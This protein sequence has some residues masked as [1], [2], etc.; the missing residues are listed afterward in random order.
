MTRTRW[1][2]FADRHLPSIVIYLMVATLVAVLLYPHMVITVPSGFIGVLWKRFCNGTV[3][4][5]RLLKNEG[6]N[7]VAPW[8]QVFLYDLRLQSFTESYNAI[9]SDGVNLTAS[10]VVR[11]R[12]QR[13]AVPVLHQAIGPNYQQVLI[14]PGI[15]SLTREVIAQYTAEQVYSTARQEIQDKIR[16]LVENRLSEKMMEHE[17]EES[18]RVSMRDTIILYDILVTGI[19]LPA[20]IVAAI[21]RKTEQYYIAEEYKFRVEREKRE[22]ERKKIEAEGVR[23]F[24]QTV[25]QGIN[26]SYLRWRGIEATLQLSQSTNS[27]VVIIGSGKDGLPIILGNVDSSAP[28]AGSAQPISNDKADKDRA[29]AP[30]PAV[31]FEKMPAAGLSTPAEK[32]P[33]VTPGAAPAAGPSPA[34]AAKAQETRSLWPITLSDIESYLARMLLPAAKTESKQPATAAE[35]PR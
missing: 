31:P 10:I 14:Q 5:P 24:Q 4:D 7:F 13:D 9:S 19:E 35:Q 17:G 15:G 26:E 8:N 16:D 32:M 12:L 6:F 34:P 25:S 2:R 3:L 20:A 29:T 21:N 30:G 22:S 23:D 27:K 18:Y 33:P 28:P 11:F 1:R